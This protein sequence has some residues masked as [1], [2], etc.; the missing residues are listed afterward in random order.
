MQCALF[1]YRTHSNALTYIKV[2]SWETS[3]ERVCF[4]SENKAL[5]ESTALWLANTALYI[6]ASTISNP[7]RIVSVCYTTK[8]IPY[9][10]SPIV[11]D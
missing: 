1:S 8:P 11:C 10:H 5:L 4:Y 6:C 7:K 2:F 9:R 3:N